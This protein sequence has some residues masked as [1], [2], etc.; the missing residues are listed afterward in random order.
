MTTFAIIAK[1]F[2]TYGFIS[3]GYH[4]IKYFEKYDLTRAH[5]IIVVGFNTLSFM[6]KM[7]LLWIVI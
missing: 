6:A 1:C 7:A 5:N 2:F 4:S 3:E